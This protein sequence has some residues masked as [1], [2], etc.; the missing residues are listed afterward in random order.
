MKIYVILLLFTTLAAQRV[1]KGILDWNITLESSD[2]KQKLTLHTQKGCA[3][4]VEGYF[5]RTIYTNLLDGS[6]HKGSYSFLD[7]EQFG[8]PV[9]WVI[10]KFPVRDIENLSTGFMID[11]VINFRIVPVVTESDPDT[12]GLL[13]NY[14]IFSDQD[15][16]RN[17]YYKLDLLTHRYHKL[18]HIPFNNHVNLHFFSEDF[19]NYN[20]IF[21][22]KKLPNKY[23]SMENMNIPAEVK[24]V[25]F[26][27]SI[28]VNNIQFNVDFVK[29]PYIKPIIYDLKFGTEVDELILLLQQKGIEKRQLIKI[30]S[31]TDHIFYYV[32]EFSFP[33]TL[34]NNNKEKRYAS[35]Q[36]RDDLFQSQYAVYIIPVER[37]Y[38]KIYKTAVDSVEK[39][40]VDVYI[41][42]KKLAINQI[43]RWTPLKKRLKLI[44]DYPVMIELP[45]E[46][47]SVH[48][49]RQGEEYNIYGYSD[50]ER[51]VN[52]YIYVSFEKL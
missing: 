45:K 35:Y 20:L 5:T 1:S 32:N 25:I 38:E 7:G 27:S 31:K 50:Y 4:N 26:D 15:K 30:N 24:K 40:T 17:K 48:F 28:T 52:E 49:T 51:F 37:A 23:E 34:Y 29:T 43:S 46:N 47:W 44:P 16:D 14:I 9:T 10:N 33:F 6:L 42:Y 2:H 13:F 8:L 11:R 21:N 36:S 19:K 12:L 18:L 41:Y 39:V 22:V 3:E